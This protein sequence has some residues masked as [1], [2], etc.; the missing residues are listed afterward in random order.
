MESNGMPRVFVS[1]ARYDS[2]AVD[3]LEPA[4]R[5]AGV[6]VWRDQESLQAGERWPK[7]LGEAIAAT[8]AFIL[9]WSAHAA[10]SDFV[11]LE[12]TTALALKKLVIPYRLDDAALPLALRSIHAVSSLDPL[13]ATQTICD[14]LARSKVPRED[15]TTRAV[16]NGLGEIAGSQPKE[17]LEAAKRTFYQ[18]GWLVQ[19]TVYQAAGD[20]HIN[21]PPAPPTR[22]PLVERWQIWVALL[23][24][25]LTAITL[26]FSIVTLVRDKVREDAAKQLP[27]QEQI[28]AGFVSGER[29]EP[30]DAV[31]IS[32]PAFQQ[33]LKTD[34]NG[35][36]RFSI[37]AAK[38]E[39][40]VLLASKTGYGEYK[41][42]ATLGNDNTHHFAFFNVR[43]M[44]SLRSVA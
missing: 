15:A 38:Q 25:I 40:V 3:A 7:A 1:Y 8:D 29:N 14:S 31:T 6:E 11:E 5:N 36:Y 41:T 9:V 19:G 30:L 28:L 33:S 26:A 4:L 39:T 27:L 44:L 22:K 23:V 35:Y 12:W 37:K 43:F 42:Y 18:Q 16:L 21:V 2:K 13:L 34:R 24:G 17:V 20:I 32:L 10:S